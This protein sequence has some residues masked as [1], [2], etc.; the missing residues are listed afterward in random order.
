MS[1]VTSGAALTQAGLWPPEQPAARLPSG[2]EP[3]EEPRPR[4][5]REPGSPCSQ[6]RAHQGQ[7]GASGLTSKHPAAGEQ[8]LPPRYPVPSPPA[9]SLGPPG[10]S[11]VRDAICPLPLQNQPP[12][13]VADRL[14]R[15]RAAEMKESVPSPRK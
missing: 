11:K 6:A 15:N 3:A 5:C 7:A 4:G 2:V 9:S 13:M 12:G 8:K 10:P 1:G 14:P